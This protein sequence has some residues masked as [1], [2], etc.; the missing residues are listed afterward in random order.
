MASGTCSYVVID[1]SKYVGLILASLFLSLK[2]LLGSVK[3]LT[4]VWEIY[5]S[6]LPL[7]YDT[8]CVAVVD[9]G[10]SRYCDF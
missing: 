10:K 5:A 2:C 6:H 3:Q 7:P 1:E 8:G 4:L 9:G